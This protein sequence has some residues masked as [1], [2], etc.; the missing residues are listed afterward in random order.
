MVFQGFAGW[1]AG[2]L[3]EQVQAGHWLVSSL[4]LDE[5]MAA[6]VTQRWDL[7]IRR[8]LQ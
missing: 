8:I 6:P 2:A 5:L 4:G 1:L 3:E 7:V